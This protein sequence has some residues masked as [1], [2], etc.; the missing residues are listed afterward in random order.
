MVPY[1]AEAS[2]LS[3][4]TASATRDTELSGSLQSGQFLDCEDIMWLLV[5][6]ITV[7]G[8]SQME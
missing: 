5:T 8:Q 1:F 2:V 3:K 6:E 4:K 7:Y